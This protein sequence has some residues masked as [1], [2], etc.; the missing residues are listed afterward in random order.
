MSVDS[1]NHTVVTANYH[2]GT[3]ESFEINEENGTVNP[4][5]S[6]MAH[7]GSYQIKKDKKTTCTLRGYT[8]DEKYVIGVDLGIDKLITYEIKDSTLTEVNSL[9]VN[10]G[11]FKT[12]YFSS[13]WKI[14]LCNDGA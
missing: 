1:G 12:H 11:V 8:P 7:E 2:K 3:I 10:P 5:S 4:A 9:S 14:R 13:K 6:I